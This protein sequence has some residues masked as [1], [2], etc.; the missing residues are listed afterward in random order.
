MIYVTLWFLY[1]LRLQ[2]NETAVTTKH[3]TTEQDGGQAC[4]EDESSW[5]PK[6]GQDQVRDRMGVLLHQMKTLV[7]KSS[8]K[9][10]LD[11]QLSGVKH[12]I[13]NVE[14]VTLYSQ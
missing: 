9:H 11:V 8:L 13:V 5:T 12:Q 4:T 6:G 3:R 14:V 1:G 10:Q 2:L 7:I